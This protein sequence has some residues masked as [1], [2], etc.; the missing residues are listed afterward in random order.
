[1]VELDSD[2]DGVPDGSDRCP[3]TASGQEVDEV[4]CPILFVVEEGVARPL[5]LR[6]VN[7][8]TNRSA[9]TPASF[10]ILNE[11]A[12]SLLAHPDVRIEIGGHT[13]NTG[14]ASYNQRLSERRALAVKAY[15]A[16]RGVSP[17]RMVAVGYGED[18]PI[19]TNATPDGRAMNRRVELRLLEGGP[20]Q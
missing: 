13:D 1:V 8:Q 15:L 2:G 14:R 20:T 16:R 4:G 17:S 12:A 3:N 11:V 6:G 10:A 18:S 5:V 9:L 7:F 19:A